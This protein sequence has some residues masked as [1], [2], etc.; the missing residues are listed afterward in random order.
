MQADISKLLHPVSTISG[1]SL[2]S[3]SLS[4]PPDDDEGDDPDGPGL[5]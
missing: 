1:S 2:W 5:I 3:V 4:L